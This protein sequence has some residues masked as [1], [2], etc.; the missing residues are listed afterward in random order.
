M[1]YRHGTK[2]GGVP[3]W[4][5]SAEHHPR[6][7]L[8][9]SEEKKALALRMAAEEKERLKQINRRA[10]EEKEL[11]KEEA[12]KKDQAD[13]QKR[14][15]MSQV[16]QS[17]ASLHLRDLRALL[18]QPLRPPSNHSCEALLQ[19]LLCQGGVRRRPSCQRESAK[20]L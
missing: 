20:R 6:G 18:R 5:G 7:K 10:N 14:I 1:K 9:G 17:P 15:N 13:L 3:Q 16:V 8:S 12:R 4:N 11:R 2:T 19:Q